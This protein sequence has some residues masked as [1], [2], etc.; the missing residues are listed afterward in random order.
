LRAE[1]G[2]GNDPGA[3]FESS[4]PTSAAQAGRPCRCD[5]ADAVKMGILARFKAAMRPAMGKL[6][7]LGG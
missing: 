7:Q 3:N 5:P 2:Q 1:S 6:A 4:G